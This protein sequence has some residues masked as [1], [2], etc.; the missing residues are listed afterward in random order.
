MDQ[1][2]GQ[3]QTLTGSFRTTQTGWPS[4][5]TSYTASTTPYHPSRMIQESIASTKHSSAE[6]TNQL[7]E[8]QTKKSSSNS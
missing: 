3:Q 8:R 6:T 5:K 7:Q 2:S 4:K 1:N